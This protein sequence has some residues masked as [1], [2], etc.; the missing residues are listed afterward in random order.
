MGVRYGE[1]D[2]TQ[3]VINTCAGQQRIYYLTPLDQLEFFT[4]FT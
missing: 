4:Y 1:Y 2:K 3:T